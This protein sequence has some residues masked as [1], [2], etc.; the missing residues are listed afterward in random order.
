MNNVNFA[1]VRLIHFP[2]PRV[3]SPEAMGPAD[4]ISRRQ[5]LSRFEPTMLLAM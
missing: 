1:V 2:S 4:A 3:R 5:V